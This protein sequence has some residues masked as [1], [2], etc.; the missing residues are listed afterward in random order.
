MRVLGLLMATDMAPPVCFPK[1]RVLERNG[2]LGSL[3]CL[4]HL[5]VLGNS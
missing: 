1:H 3:G 2:W 4:G 5:L